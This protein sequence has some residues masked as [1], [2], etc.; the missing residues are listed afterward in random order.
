MTNLRTRL[1]EHFRKTYRT[2]WVQPIKNRPN[3]LSITLFPV[4]QRLNYIIL[5]TKGF[6]EISFREI[7]NYINMETGDIKL[8]P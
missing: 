2:I 3:Y 6:S 8:S 5:P 1:E 4:D 7:V